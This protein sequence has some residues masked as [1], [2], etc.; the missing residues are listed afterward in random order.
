MKFR[1]LLF[2]LKYSHRNLWRRKNRTFLLGMSFFVLSLIIVLFLGYNAGLSRQMLGNAIDNF[3]GNMAIVAAKSDL[4]ALH[5][6]KAVPFEKE[7]VIS[8]LA[9]NDDSFEFWAEYKAKAFFFTENSMTH[10]FLVGIDEGR[11]KAFKITEGDNIEPR[12]GRTNEILLPAA[13]AE[14]LHVAVGDDIGL[15][16]VTDQGLR[17]IDYFTVKGLYMIPGVVEIMAGHLAYTSIDDVRFLMDVGSG[18]VTNIL[19]H[20]KDERRVLRS[21]EYIE[22][23]LDTKEYRVMDYKEYGS[24]LVA[25]MTFFVILG[26]SVGIIA[27]I[28]ITIFFFD[29]I[30]A[31]VEERKKEYGI[32]I[33]MGLANFRINLLVLCEFAVFTVYFVLPAVAVGGLIVK[34]L[35]NIGLS[36]PRAVQ[37][38]MGGLE[39]FSPYMDIALAGK[40]FLCILALIELANIYSIRKINGLNPVEVLKNE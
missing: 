32:M 29:T 3:L 13:I 16:V 14:D 34:M 2:Y 40:T 15:E 9:P 11:S 30:L 5:L 20:S 18:A 4:D 17:N 23:I 35:A 22:N 6:D 10:A 28:V 25:L 33:S 19:L 26:W 27:I 8:K 31:T 24:M 12:P 21:K 39:G 37:T 36:I 38:F 1:P 7:D